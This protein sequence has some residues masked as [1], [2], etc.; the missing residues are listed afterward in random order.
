MAEDKSYGPAELSGLEWGQLVP[1]L[2]EFE[3]KVAEMSSR[4]LSTA[5]SV[6]NEYTRLGR[7]PSRPQTLRKYRALRYVPTQDAVM[8]F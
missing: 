8:C 5:N 1:M 6:K 7:P 4:D 2:R 3:K